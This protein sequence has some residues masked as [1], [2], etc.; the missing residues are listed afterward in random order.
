MANQL[1]LG[2]RISMGFAVVILITVV[3]GSLG[4]W[5]MLSAKNDSTK[6]ATEYIPEVEISNALRG[7][8]NRVMYA[9]RGFGLSENATYYEEAKQEMITL[10]THLKEADELASRAVHLDALEGQIAHATEAVDQY[11]ELMEQTEKTI[12]KMAEHRQRLDENAASYIQNCADFLDGQNAAFKKDLDERQKKIGIVTSILDLGTEVRVANFKARVNADTGLIEEAIEQIGDL[13]SRT[14]ELRE[15]TRQQANIGQIDNIEN[16]AKAYEKAMHL[17]LDESG[18]DSNDTRTAAIL[19][20]QKQMDE[21]AGSYVE[22]CN[23]FLQSQ[24]EQLTADMHMRTAKI[25]LA[26]DIIHLGNDARVKAFKAQATR[27]MNLVEKALENFAKLDEK[28]NALREITR[29]DVDLKRIDQVQAAGNNYARALSEFGEQWHYLAKLGKERTETGKRV[30]EACTTIADVGMSTTR[31]L[32]TGSMKSLSRS[33]IVMVAGLAVGVT[34]A[35]LAA[36]WIT[37]SI[38]RLLKKIIEGLNDGAEQVASAANQVSSSSQQMAEGASEQASS[39]EETSSSLEEMS[40]MTKQ[41][42]DSAQQ[43]DGL[44]AE[45]KAVVHKADHSMNQL[46]ESMDEI[47][48]ASEETSKIVKTIDEIA[49]Q[50]NLL[51]LNA[52]VEAARAGEAGAGFAVVADEVRNLAMR[53]ADAAKN[54]AALIEGTVKK[55][56]EGSALVSMTN[57]EFRQVAE[58]SARV[59]ELVAEIAAASQEQAQGI[60]Q[61]NKAVSE[62]DKV[63]QQNAAN[64][65][66]NASASEELSSQAEQMRVYVEELM[67]L[68]GGADGKRNNWQASGNVRKGKG[69]GMLSI[70]RMTARANPV[71]RRGIKEV[72]PDQ[73]IPMDEDEFKD[74]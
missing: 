9:M 1:T 52:A 51:A 13:K 38:T 11:A 2:K 10:R 29:L 73:I 36:L 30:V 66:E 42:A 47:S 17:Y 53:A 45:G 55:V 65:E 50:T 54:T 39:I 20:Y 33:S 16:A 19:R 15:I 64:S 26:N 44:M 21:A 74:F 3:L 70:P 43:A 4:V 14:G 58:S 46:T 31:K 62:M 28:Y 5:N 34:L 63:V 61:V 24:Q 48:K 22:F 12:V 8:A 59:A 6:L 49:F 35:I 60:E 32:S 23:A 27:D 25:L 67:A 7:D 72:S 18:Q 57:E 41:N 68:V 69:H 71:A 37:R 40:S 56:G